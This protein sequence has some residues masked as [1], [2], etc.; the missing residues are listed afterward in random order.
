MLPEGEKLYVPEG[1]NDDVG[2]SVGTIVGFDAGKSVG[3]IV[4][5]DVGKSVGIM[6]GFDVGDSVGI[7]VGFDVGKSV[8]IIVGFDVGI[9]V[10][11]DVGDSVGIIVGFDVGDVV[12]SNDGDSDKTKVPTDLRCCEDANTTVADVWGYISV[13]KAIKVISISFVIF[14]RPL[15]RDNNMATSKILLITPVECS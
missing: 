12:G 10:G 8:G 14:L 4:G 5:F 13:R 9:I 7:I 6:V 1:H 11:F 15:L 2:K 3:T